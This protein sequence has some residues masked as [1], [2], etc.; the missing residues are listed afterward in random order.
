MKRKTLIMTTPT[1]VVTCNS[2]EKLC[3][4]LTIA[5]VV[6]DVQPMSRVKGSGDA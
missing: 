6:G 4:T 1:E 2:V 5:K 3:S